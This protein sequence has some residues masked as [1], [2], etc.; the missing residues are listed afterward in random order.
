[1]VLLRGNI[2]EGL[3]GGCGIWPFVWLMRQLC[4][5]LM[6]AAD[7]EDLDVWRGRN[8]N[9]AARDAGPLD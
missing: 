7:G 4:E 1:M 6:T 2:E 3:H 5:G 9:F 8:K